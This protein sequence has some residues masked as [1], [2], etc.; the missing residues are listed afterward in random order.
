MFQQ[1]Q[2]ATDSE[3]IDMEPR[4]RQSMGRFEAFT[5]LVSQKKCE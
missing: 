1:V 5:S 2:K 3:E 4:Q